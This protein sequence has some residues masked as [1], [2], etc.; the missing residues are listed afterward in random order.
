MD[1]LQNKKYENYDYVSRYSSVPYYYHT[2]DDKNIYGVGSNVSKNTPYVS[3]KVDIHDT[4]DSLA[5]RYY[6]NPTLWW[7][8]AYFNDIQ[9]AFEP[10]HKRFT[11]I[12][13]PSYATLQFGEER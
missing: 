12:K 1:V 10:L 6:S 2:Q 9:D 13:I 8:I 7:H 5:L 11:V 4:L 3:H